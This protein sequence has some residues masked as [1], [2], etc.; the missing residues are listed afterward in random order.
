MKDNNICSNN[1]ENKAK[2]LNAE[3]FYRENKAETLN[4]ELFA[5]RSADNNASAELN[6]YIKK[7]ENVGA[8]GREHYRSFDV[9]TVLT[10][11][12]A[13][14]LS[15]VTGFFGA[16]VGIVV[17][18]RSGFNASESLLGDLMLDASG[19]ETHKVIV[20]ETEL[21]YSGG[22]IEISEKLIV[23]VVEVDKLKLNEEG[24]AYEEKGSASGV[25]ISAD[26]YI[27]TNEHVTNGMDKIRVT[28]FDGVEYIADIIEEDSI[29]DLAVIKVKLP[30][31]VSLTPA[32]FGVSANAKL[33]QSVVVIGNPKNV[34][35]SVSTGVI[36]AVDR[37][38]VS[39]DD[40][41]SVIQTDSA[42]SPGNSGSGL[43]DV[44]GN[45]LGIVCSKTVGVDIEGLGYA[46][47]SDTVKAVVDDLLKYGYVR[48]R[49]ALG[50]NTVSIFDSSSYDKYRNGT[51]EGYLFNSRYGVY[52]VGSLR[53]TELKRGDRLIKIDGDRVTSTSVIREKLKGRNPGETMV[54]TVERLT[55]DPNDGNAIETLDITV[56][57][58]ERDW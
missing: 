17:L 44:Y 29:T 55:P 5:A 21:S 56:E 41:I 1:G 34:G 12:V 25:I 33:G 4:A 2:A 43:F 18:S 58:Y 16:V 36:S 30:D 19:V 39:G 45:L 11:V 37:E 15:A 6:A 50:I 51:L 46:V 48:G 52:I 7:E 40:I 10:A 22:F 28:T 20:D 31:G 47:P 8:V 27:L 14:I 49:V 32:V 42:V 13:C 9:R 54:L 26:G 3:L 57:L 35:L 24:N 23:S 53:S 38:I